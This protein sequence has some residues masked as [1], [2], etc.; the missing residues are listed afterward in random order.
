MKQKARP[1][2]AFCFILYKSERGGIAVTANAVIFG[3]CVVME[4]STSNL[5]V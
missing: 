5:Y 1:K 3:A 4:Y 2:R